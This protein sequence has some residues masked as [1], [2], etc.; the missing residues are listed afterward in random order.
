MRDMR[1][2]RDMQ[3]LQDMR[4]M[5][6]MREL[7]ELRDMRELWE[8]RSATLRSAAPALPFPLWR[9]AQRER[10]EELGRPAKGLHRL[11]GKDLS[12]LRYSRKLRNCLVF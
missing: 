5:R 7:R 1:D 2:I 4:D 6:D 12:A 8:M 10:F 3:E 9:S 11:F